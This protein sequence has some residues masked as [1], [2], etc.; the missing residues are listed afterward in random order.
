MTKDK[1]IS[2]TDGNDK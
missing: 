2:G 1:L